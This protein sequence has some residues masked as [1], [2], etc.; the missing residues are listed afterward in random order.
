[1]AL[2]RSAAA[3]LAGPPQRSLTLVPHLLP[4]P[5]RSRPSHPLPGHRRGLPGDDASPQWSEPRRIFSGA[6]HPD[7]LPHLTDRWETTLV[8]HLTPPPWHSAAPP[9]HSALR[10]VPHLPAASLLPHLRGRLGDDARSPPSSIAIALS[11]LVGK[12]EVSSCQ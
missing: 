7:S 12:G 10:H 3:S 4:P 2:S 5:W 8:P 6:R 11:R 1:M 9:R